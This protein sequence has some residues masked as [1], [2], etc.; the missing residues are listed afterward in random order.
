MR[1]RI[2]VASS[3]DNPQQSALVRNA[4]QSVGVGWRIGVFL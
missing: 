2:Y 4:F 1:R 3:W